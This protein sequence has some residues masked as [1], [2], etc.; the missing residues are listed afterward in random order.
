MQ[1]K[2]TKQNLVK[3]FLDGLWRQHNIGR[4][5]HMKQKKE[6]DHLRCRHSNLGLHFR[7]LLNLPRS[8]ASEPLP[9]LGKLKAL[10]E[11]KSRS[12]DSEFLGTDGKTSLL[13]YTT[14]TDLG[15]L[16]IA[17]AVSVE[18]NV[19]KVFSVALEGWRMLRSNCILMTMWDL[20]MNCT[21]A[22][23]FVNE[24]ILKLV[25]NP[26]CNSI[27]ELTQGAMLYS[28]GDLN[29]ADYISRYLHG[30]AKSHLWL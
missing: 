12:V 17:N 28:R 18:R 23:H 16:Q 13:G 4:F 14:A 3:H 30:N 24:R 2:S 21:D 25:L 29:P 15:I 9:V 26:C 1:R 5:L 20:F 27:S 8:S 11:S 6:G 22:S 10:V 7:C 19:F